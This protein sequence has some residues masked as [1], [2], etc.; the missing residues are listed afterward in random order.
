MDRHAMPLSPHTLSAL[1]A[2]PDLL[3]RL[4]RSFPK[5]SALWKPSSWEGIPGEAFAALEQICHVRDIE[6]DGYQVRIR[7]LLA[8]QHPLLVSLDGYALAAERRYAEADGS[9]VLA[10]FRAARRETV[11]LLGTVSDEQ[12]QRRGEF[13]GFGPVTLAGV[14]HLLSSHDQQ[15]LACL[16][17]LLAKLAS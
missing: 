6:I 3:E 9:D 1:A 2:M 11:A 4:F 13:E 10:S 16:H 7:R 15:H 5:D 12:L 17:W 8:E 14:V